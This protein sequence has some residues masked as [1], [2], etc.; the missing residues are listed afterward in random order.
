[1]A[2][3]RTAM[4]GFATSDARDRNFFLV[5]ALLIW[6]VTIAGFGLEMVQR[7]A[8]GKLHYPLVVHAH[9][10]AFI[11]WLALFTTQIALI[12]QGN[13]RLHLRI[14][15]AAVALIP[16]MAIL[17]IAT[18]IITKTLKYGHPDTSFPFMSIQFTNVIAS[19]VLLV[20]GFLLRRSSAAHKRLMLMGTLV[21]TEPGIRRVVS[22]FLDGNFHEGFWPFMAETYA[23]TIALMLGLGAYDFFTRNRLHPAYVMAFSWC[24]ANQL[25]A[26]WLF[27][28]P[29]WAQTTTRLV[30][31]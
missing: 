29:W 7:F 6:A 15:I 8:E 24:V 22:Y 17:S 12:R 30:G 14:G 27:Y 23:G 2:D 21:L 19:T 20:A 9:A 16:L 5:Y 26:T 28:Q 1:M 10:I 11:A 25:V 4:H 13:Y 3:N 31:H 18:V